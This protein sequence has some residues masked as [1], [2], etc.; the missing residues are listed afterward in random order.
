MKGSRQFMVSAFYPAKPCTG[1]EQALFVDL[2]EPAVE[3]AISYLSEGL[4]PELQD[5]FRVGLPSIGMQAVR[6]ADG[7]PSAS[8]CPVLIYYPAGGSNRFG[9]VDVCEGLASQGFVVLA[10]DGPHDAPLVV[11]P[12]GTLCKGPLKGDYIT[13]GVADVACL[14]GALDEINADLGGIMD[15]SRVGLFGHSRGGYISNIAA[16][17]HNAV[18]AVASIDCFLWGFATK[19]TGLERHPAEFQARVRSTPKSVLRLCGRPAGS[20]PQEEADFCLQR[21]SQDFV[22]D[23]AV[24]AFPGWQHGDFRTTPWLCGKGPDLVES[25]SRGQ[26]IAGEIITGVLTAFFKTSLRGNGPYELDDYVLD[27]PELGLARRL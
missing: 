7:S 26:S 23:F 9:S 14:I 1:G 12:G 19:G 3:E 4:S 11:F 2:F 16:Y 22:G 24:V 17:Q 13:P 18:S 15:I 21:D 5:R 10:I 6:N 20:L 25:H 8:H 27:R